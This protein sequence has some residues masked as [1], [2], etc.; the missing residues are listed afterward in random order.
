[1][2]IDVI[3]NEKDYAEFILE[4]EKHSFPNLL[5]QKLLDNSAVEFVSYLVEHPNDK[6]AKFVLKTKGKTPKKVL[7]DASKEVEKD[8][9]EFEK[10]I[11]KTVK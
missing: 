10:N 5:K 2:K 4:G 1:M 3:K 7:E 11:K 9:D 6:K 8:L